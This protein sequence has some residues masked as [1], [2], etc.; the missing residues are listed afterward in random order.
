MKIPWVPITEGAGSKGPVKPTDEFLK[1]Y[2]TASNPV[3]HK[4]FKNLP[5]NT[6]APAV[7]VHEQN[8]K[9]HFNATK[10]RT[11]GEGA[12]ENYVDSFVTHPV[13]GNYKVIVASMELQRKLV[14]ANIIEQMS[15]PTTMADVALWGYRDLGAN[16][17]EERVNALR[18]RL[19]F[20]GASDAQIEEILTEQKK[21]TLLAK[22]KIPLT[23]EQRQIIQAEEM[24]RRA[25]G[26]GAVAAGNAGT[27]AARP[28][29]DPNVFNFATPSSASYAGYVSAPVPSNAAFGGLSEVASRRLLPPGMTEVSTRYTG[30]GSVGEMLSS[31]ARVR[32]LR[33]EH[34]DWTQ[35]RIAQE[36]GVSQ[37]TVSRILRV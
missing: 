28:P 22:I 1:N 27:L 4:A 19:R 7:I 13:K 20:A 17:D 11:H 15:N 31:A 8:P 36:A 14:Q 29:M 6:Q 9:G 30:G 26:P 32:G 5:M 16:A 2:S 25:M 37:P 3:S 34:P 18:D 35:A 23:D 10:V 24:I 33:S 21:Q 12:G